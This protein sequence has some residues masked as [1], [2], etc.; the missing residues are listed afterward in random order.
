ME[1][2][3]LGH[4]CF[5]LRSENQVVIT[6]PFPE[7]LG[8]QP[9]SRPAT[10]VT[11]S[12]S[13]PNH[14]HWEGVTGEPRVLSAPGEYQYAGVSVRGIM[15]PLAPGAP[16]EQR[17]VAYSISLDGVNI[18]HLGDINMPITPR[19]VEE[20]SPAD[21]LL[22][23]LGGGCTL[24]LEE[25]LKV[26]ENLAPKIVIPMHYRIPGVSVPLQGLEGFLRRMGTGQ[27]E[28]QPRLSVTP[29]NLPEDLRIVLLAPQSRQA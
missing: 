11:V 20:L 13:H 10:V 28:P 24:E 8:L 2:T 1:I 29:S 21:V 16:Q 18:C 22:V 15:T 27:T 5:R 26:M 9:D 23:P 14:S 3:W 19:Q 12:N 7:S 25:V 17:N 6:D 4:A